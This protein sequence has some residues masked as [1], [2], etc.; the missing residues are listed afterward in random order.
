MD[1]YEKLL[2]GAYEKVKPVEC[3]D[4]FEIKQVEGHIQGKKTIVSN[5][6]AISTCLRRNPE[7]LA[8]FLFKELAAPGEIIGERLSLTRKVSSQ[9]INEKIKKYS[10]LFIL[11]P[12]CKKPDTELIDE[13][14]KKIIRCLA[15][16]HKKVLG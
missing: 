8:K 10:N 14:G 6:V 1:N 11:C 16:G 4:R 13:G 12:N 2:E 5:F 15:C 3:C 9:N 7:H